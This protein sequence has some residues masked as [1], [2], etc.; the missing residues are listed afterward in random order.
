[1]GIFGKLF[2]KKKENKI[3]DLNVMQGDTKTDQVE[4]F[5]K[6]QPGSTD[7]FS[8]FGEKGLSESAKE[9][10]IKKT[11]ASVERGKIAFVQKDNFRYYIC[12]M[13]DDE[14]D[15]KRIIQGTDPSWSKD[16]KQLAFTYMSGVQD[17]CIVDEDGS[18]MKALTAN[19]NPHSHDSQPH[20]GPD[21]KHIVFTSERDTDHKQIFI[22][23]TTGENQQRITNSH[24]NH[25]DLS[26]RISP[27][28]EKIVFV[29][30]GYPK[31]I[32]VMDIDGSNQTS[33][34]DGYCP[35]WSPDGNGILF[36]RQGR[37]YFRNLLDDLEK[38]IGVGNYPTYAY[39]GKKIVFCRGEMDREQIWIMER[40]GQDASPIIENQK[41]NINP[42]WSPH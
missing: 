19:Q 41:G 21:G 3:D 15:W 28:G 31:A 2:G 23:T 7:G 33:L 37:I 38:E 36:V 24:F 11:S 14:K 27:D 9:G 12:V 34:C 4:F 8:R 18:N 1:M 30:K 20:W 26:P 5:Q 39:N 16:G 10:D 6:G 29:R 40:S 17:V 13:N 22:M 32:H 25:P 42:V 35:S